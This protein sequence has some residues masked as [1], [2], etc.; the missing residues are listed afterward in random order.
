[1][2]CAQERTHRRVV[3]RWKGVDGVCTT[4]GGIQETYGRESES[5]HGSQRARQTARD[6]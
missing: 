3:R 6:S 2:C 5:D 1:M 4:G